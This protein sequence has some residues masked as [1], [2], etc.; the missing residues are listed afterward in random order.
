[1]QT[2]V[3]YSWLHSDDPRD[4][5]FWKFTFRRDRLPADVW[6]KAAD[7]NARLSRRLFRGSV[8]LMGFGNIVELPYRDTWL[9]AQWYA[10]HRAWLCI[11]G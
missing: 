5:R 4:D 11:R 7:A 1:M 9:P 2:G 10:P 8:E 6:E 3:A